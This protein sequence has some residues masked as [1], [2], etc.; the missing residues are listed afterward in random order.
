VRRLSRREDSRKHV[1]TGSAGSSFEH[2]R[3]IGSEWRRRIQL[4]FSMRLRYFAKPLND[5][6]AATRESTRS[7]TMKTFRTT[8]IIASAIIVALASTAV[9]STDMANA[10]GRLRQNE[11]RQ[12]R[13]SG[14]IL[15]MEEILARVRKIQ[16]GE[17]VEI[18]LER[19]KESYVYEVKV[20]DDKS[21]IHK[22][23]VDAGNG[24]VLRRKEK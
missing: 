3:S 2:N 15:P 1:T 7:L 12:L 24:E 23:E 14:K 4:R 8:P 17:V 18:E 22:L 19:K 9:F 16:P 6:Q 20:I 13:E 11:V 21:A 5:R 10:D